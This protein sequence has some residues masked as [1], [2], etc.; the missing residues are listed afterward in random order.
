MSLLRRFWRWLQLAVPFGLLVSTKPRHYREM[1]RVLWRN[2]G[3]WRY[4]LRILQHGV[5]DGCS[6][7][8]RG[9]RDDVILGVHLCLTRLGLLALNT[10]RPI[11]DAA[12]A[13]IRG[14]RAMTNEQLHRLGRVPY[15]LVRRPG[16]PGF[17]RI[18]WEEAT[19]IAAGVDGPRR[20]GGWRRQ[21]GLLRQLAR[22]RR[23]RSTTLIQKLARIAGTAN[24]DSCARLCHAASATGLK[25]TIGWGA[26]DLLAQ[27]HDR[28]GPARAHRHRPGEQP[29]GDDEVHALR[30]GAGDAHRRRQSVPRAGARALLGA[31]GGEVGAVRHAADA[32]DFFAVRPGGDI[33]FSDRRAQGALR[34]SA[35]SSTR[36]TSPSA[37]SGSRRCAAAA[38]G[39]AR[40]RSATPRG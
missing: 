33:G 40:T 11:P 19:C 36:R 6:L 30:Q 20:F 28:H 15:P 26:S 31:V 32:D 35:T 1:L 17:A 25:A 13:D 29:A 14:L 10:M 22:P 27:R 23:T 7:G 38:R 24:V 21:D 5:C 3:R 37:P 34:T 9:L 16:D 8:P 39:G 12:L 2:R 4:A 18:S